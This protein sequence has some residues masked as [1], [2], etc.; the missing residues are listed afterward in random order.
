MGVAGTANYVW[1]MVGQYATGQ[2]RFARV[3]ASG[4]YEEPV[5]IIPSP[6]I[7]SRSSQTMF[8]TFTVNPD[9]TRIWA[10]F[11]RDPG[12]G[13]WWYDFTPT[14][15]FWNGATWQVRS[16]IAHGD[17]ASLGFS[18]G[19]GGSVGWDTGVVALMTKTVNTS[20]NGPILLA[21]MRAPP[22][23]VGGGAQVSAEGLYTAGPTGNSTDRVTVTDFAGASASATVTVP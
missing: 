1:A 7:D 21:T 2:V 12:S 20:F 14:G 10:I 19:L 18:N 11:T 4:A 22:D 13:G 5:A 9:E 3:N 15:A 23:G 8:G 17:S 16:D 6:V